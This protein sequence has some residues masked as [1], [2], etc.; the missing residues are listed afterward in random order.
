MITQGFTPSYFYKDS[1]GARALIDPFATT[2]A[3]FNPTQNGL[4]AICAVG[5]PP[6][7]ADFVPSAGRALISKSGQTISPVLLNYTG[8]SAGFEE[9]PGFTVPGT[10]G[11][12]APG[13]ES[14]TAVHFRLQ[15]GESL[16]LIATSP[17]SPGVL[18]AFEIWWLQS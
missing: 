12:P 6:P 8:A 10:F 15:E 18:V 1:Y 3:E 13:S 7:V 14:I 17:K 11:Y 5:V 16:Y 2:A 9:K 4:F